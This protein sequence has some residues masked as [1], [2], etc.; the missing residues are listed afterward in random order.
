MTLANPFQLP[1]FCALGVK[2]G[3]GSTQCFLMSTDGP[4]NRQPTED[5]L[6]IDKGF[7]RADRGILEGNWAHSG[8]NMDFSGQHRAPSG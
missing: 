2:S 4:Q 8:Q 5:H 3:P 6:S 7:S 1:P